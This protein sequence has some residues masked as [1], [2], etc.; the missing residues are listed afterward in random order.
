MTI[1]KQL[2]TL[3][4]TVALAMCG[5]GFGVVVVANAR[6]QQRPF[7]LS[8]GQVEQIIRNVER[9]ADSF[10]RSLDRELDRSR[11]DGTEREDE[12]NNLVKA[13]E[14]ATNNLRERFNGERSVAADV[15]NVLE[16]AARID[17]F[18]R[19]NLRYGP[20]QRDWSLLKR[21]L[22]RLA[23]AYNVTFRFGNQALPPSLVGQQRPYRVQ[24]RQV[25]EVLRRMETRANRFRRDLD[26]TIDRSRL[27]GTN[28]EDNINELV[29]EFESA[30]EE[31]RKRFDARRSV[32]GDVQA[33]LTRARRIDEFLRRNLQLRRVQGIWSL[34]RSDLNQL[35]RYYN[36][37]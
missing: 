36:V 27:D 21:D 34:L 28:R 16:R 31:L 25:E 1:S 20:V 18:I 10:R 24:D 3:S 35:A 23:N 19:A 26:S 4:L 12:A 8:D 17:D 22:S 33:V 9:R 15:Q 14:E 5:L 7:R 37:T 30:T 11:L 29:K 6:V 32:A 2:T 13:F